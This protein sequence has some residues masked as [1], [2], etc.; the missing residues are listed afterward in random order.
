VVTPTRLPLGL[1]S[2]GLSGAVVIA[3]LLPVGFK[4]G[5]S[6]GYCYGIVNWYNNEVK[7]GAIQAFISP[8]M[9]LTV[10]KHQYKSPL[11]AFFE[12]SILSI[13]AQ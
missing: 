11:W 2:D 8:E 1:R 4:P 5:G 12:I 13:S 3:G 7:N 10:Q 6:S 9:Q